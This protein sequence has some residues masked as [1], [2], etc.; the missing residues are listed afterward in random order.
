MGVKRNIDSGRVDSLGRPIKVSG[1][2]G[3]ISSDAKMGQITDYG[4]VDGQ[5]DIDSMDYNDAVDIVRGYADAPDEVISELKRLRS[6]YIDNLSIDDLTTIVSDCNGWDG[7]L[8]EYQLYEADSGELE[9]VCGGD[10]EKLANMIH[11]GD[12]NPFHEY[13]TLDGYGNIK[14]YSESDYHEE[15][16]GTREEIYERYEDLME[17]SPQYISDDYKWI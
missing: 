11:F 10:F 14:T 1:D 12:Y 13:F 7:S 15:L 3:D 4:D 9:V 5:W 6:E 17:E 8:E 16:D 2:K